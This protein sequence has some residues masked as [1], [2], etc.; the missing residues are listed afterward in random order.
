[1]LC[2]A[3][4]AG[5]GGLSMGKSQRPPRRNERQARPSAAMRCSCRRSSFRWSRSLARS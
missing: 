1:V 3:L 2:M 5:F 4:V